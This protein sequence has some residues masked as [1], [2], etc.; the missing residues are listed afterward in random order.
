M[1]TQTKNG[2]LYGCFDLLSDIDNIIGL[3]GLEKS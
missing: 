2:V 1:H 3:N